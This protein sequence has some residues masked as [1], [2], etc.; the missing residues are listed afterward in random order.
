MNFVSR[1]LA[2]SSLSGRLMVLSWLG[3]FAAGSVAAQAPDPD[4]YSWDIKAQDS[5]V[6]PGDTVKATTGITAKAGGVQGWSYGVSHDTSVLTIESA[7]T[8]GTDTLTVFQNGFDQTVIIEKD[9]VKQGFIQAIVLSLMKKAE[10]PISDYFTMAAMTYKVNNNAC[11]GKSGDF[12]SRV[13]YTEEL[14]VEG[15]PP[16]DW[17][18][19]V[20][21]LSLVPGDIS[22]LDLSIQCEGA[23]PTE[24][25][26]KFDQRDTDLVADQTST[27][28]LKVLLENPGSSVDV[29]GWSYGVS[30]DTRELEATAGEPGADGAAVNGGS[31]PEFKSYDLDEAGAGPGGGGVTVGVV[32]DI[33]QGDEILRIG[34]RQTRHLD[35]ITLR[36][37][38]VIPE[39]GATKTVDIRLIDNLGSP[40]P[41]E[42]LVV[43]ASDG[44]VPDFSD[45]LA[46]TLQPR[47]TV[48][49]QRF[50]RGDANDDDVVDIADGLWIINDLFYTGPD[51]ACLRAAD[52]NDDD[53]VDVGDAMFIFNYQLQ[54]ERTP[55]NLFPQPPAPFPACGTDA[56]STLAC[57]E[58]STSC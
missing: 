39:G 46:L 55:G 17:N 40:E 23:S 8:E 29:Q 16:V 51:T 53:K 24:L 57:P 36:S 30:F 56:T 35:T 12:K 10:V 1:Q 41:I 37:K 42:V 58:G 47:G 26:M 38:N 45:T 15:S 7:T 14:G 28:D 4:D 25:V 9:G 6:G 20:G 21:G 49:A 33:D 2:G 5:S 52:A 22:A 18:I 54:P 3:V 31:G 13:L 34:S 19:T 11:N 44:I 32:I 43:V 48:E 50:I 27:Y